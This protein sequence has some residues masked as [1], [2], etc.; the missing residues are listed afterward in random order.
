MALR[1]E[2]SSSIV[3]LQVKGKPQ[4]RGS[5]AL[6]VTNSSEKFQACKGEQRSTETNM[7][8]KGSQQAVQ[9]AV[10]QYKEVQLQEPYADQLHFGSI[11]R[12][13]RGLQIM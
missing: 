4:A 7:E 13:W 12:S 11:N 1:R 3:I 6:A 5:S 2:A 9:K 8:A 10:P